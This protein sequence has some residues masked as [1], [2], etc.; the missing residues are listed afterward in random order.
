MSAVMSSFTGVSVSEHFFFIFFLLIFRVESFGKGF[1]LMNSFIESS[2]DICSSFRQRSCVASASGSMLKMESK[3]PTGPVL[4][5]ETYPVSASLDMVA[6][7]SETFD[8]RKP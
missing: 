8:E 6:I 1:V 3:C 4:G 2:A 7:L 5:I